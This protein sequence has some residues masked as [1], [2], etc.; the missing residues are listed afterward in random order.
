MLTVGSLSRATA[1]GTFPFL[2]ERFPGRRNA[3]KE[4]THLAPDFVF[5]IYPDGELFD[6]RDAHRSHP[7]PGH[8]SILRDEP[9][10]GGFLRGRVASNFGPPLVVVYCRPEALAEDP[11]KMAQFLDGISQLP[12]PLDDSTLVVSDNADLYGTIADLEARLA[13]ITGL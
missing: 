8:E 9:D 1:A 11:A 5:W 2:A 6:A 7:P 4:F 12:I 13:E 3:I 10:Y